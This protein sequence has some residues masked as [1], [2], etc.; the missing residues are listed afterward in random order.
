MMKEWSKFKDRNPGA[1]L[2]CI[3]VQPYATTQAQSREDVLNIGGFSDA[4]FDVVAQF[5]AG[6]LDADLFVSEI[7]KG[8]NAVVDYI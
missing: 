8:P 7:E 6:K 4:V 5:A 3:D 2:V 1:R